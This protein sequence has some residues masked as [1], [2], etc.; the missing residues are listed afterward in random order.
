MK[1]AICHPSVRNLSRPSVAYF[2][3]KHVRRVGESVKLAIA[4]CPLT[5]VNH[6]H[7]LDLED[8][9]VIIARPATGRDSEPVPSASQLTFWLPKTSRLN[10][11]H[12]PLTS[13]NGRFPKGALTK[14]KFWRMPHQECV[15]LGRL[16]S[17]W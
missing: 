13:T 2:C 14:M 17:A 15:D 8:S 11:I 6:P 7:V 12:P 4:V 10:V 1:F 9:A 16:N 3:L 5:K